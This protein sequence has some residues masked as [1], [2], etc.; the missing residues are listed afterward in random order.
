MMLRY[1]NSKGDAVEFGGSPRK[2][3]WGETDL[4]GMSAEYQT[5][6]GAVSSWNT[7]LREMG[8]K[9]HL[10]G[11]APG[12]LDRLIDVVTYDTRANRPGT[13]WC[14]G[15]WMRC[16][17][18]G[19]D[20]SNYWQA[21]G[22]IADLDLVVVSDEPV[23]VRSVSI[24][25]TA[26]KDEPAG[27]LN[28][29]H[30]FPHN[31]LRGTGATAYVENPFQLPAKCDIAIPGPCV[32]PYV[33]IGGNR[34]QVNATVE[35]GQILFIR[36]YGERDVVVR[37]SDGTERSVFDQRVREAGAMPFAEVPVGRHVASWSGPTTSR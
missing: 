5:I 23:W 33:I 8:L 28:F 10:R 9:A 30:N 16:W 12:D 20:L 29:P 35:K 7:P 3:F 37:H 11:G 2:L 24:T 19:F 6:G 13:L 1:V 25:L 22:E 18:G 36:G 32:S 27:G 26:R 4:F 21:P 31:Y 17:V 14:N 34:Y 15:C